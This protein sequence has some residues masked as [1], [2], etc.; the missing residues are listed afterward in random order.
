MA[1]EAWIRLDSAVTA[2]DTNSEFFEVTI[3]R[4]SVSSTTGYDG[5]YMVRTI[6]AVSALSSVPA[7]IQGSTSAHFIDFQF[8]SGSQFA[9]SLTS[10]C[11]YLLMN[12]IMF[13]VN[14]R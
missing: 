8:A 4:N 5:N 2:I 11:I 12:G 1:L 9:Y 6:Y 14:G 3:Q 10:T 13:G 7:T